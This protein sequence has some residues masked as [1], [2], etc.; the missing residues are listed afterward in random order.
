MGTIL[1]KIGYLI[2]TFYFKIKR[3]QVIGRENIP[4]KGPLIVMA[5]HVGYL[6]PPAVGCA[7]TRKVHFM[8]KKELFKNPIS[9]WVLHKIGSFPV[10]R[11]KPDR[12]AIKK[13]FSIL[14]EDKVLGIFPEGGTNKSGE[15]K[16][17]RPGA[18]MIALRSGATI[19]PVGISYQ[20]GLKVSIGSPLDFTDGIDRE[21]AGKMIMEAIRSEL[22]T[23]NRT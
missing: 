10:K 8:A 1:Y 5:N 2:F 16:P 17:A 3:W 21:Q 15:L 22:E 11:G 23:L 9:D 12:G 6:D 4:D 18:V 13:A 7:M 19:L 14:E 20:Q